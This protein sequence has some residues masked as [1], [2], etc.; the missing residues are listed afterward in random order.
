MHYFIPKN[1]TGRDF[2]VGD[3]HGCFELLE[4]TMRYHG[5]DKAKDRLFSVGDIIDRGPESEKCLSLLS[6]SWFHMV[7]GNHEQM[8]IDFITGG[9][10]YNWL[11]QYGGWARKMQTSDLNDYVKS[12]AKLPISLTLDCGEFT[13]GVCHAEP[14]GDDWM[15]SRD[16]AQ[17]RNIMMWGRKVLKELPTS[18]L[19]GVDIS[20]HGHTP[21]ESPKWIGNRY[22]MDTD[23]WESGNLTFRNIDDIF[24][25]YNALNKLFS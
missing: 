11:S 18:K 5:F 1:E 6:E 13:V 25:E 12:L 2:I 7:M 19:T 23:A 9:Q 8:M 10:G 22:F 24:A 17:S 4:T 16:D 15:K 3:I 21:L 14:D 20:I